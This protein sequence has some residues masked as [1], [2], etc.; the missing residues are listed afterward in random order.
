MKKTI[1]LLLLLLG[2][3]GCDV[4]RGRFSVTSNSFSAF[5][6]NIGGI[7][8]VNGFGAK[9]FNTT[10]TDEQNLLY[11][12]IVGP[13]VQTHGSSSASGFEKYVT[14]LDYSWNAEKSAFAVSIHWNR[15]TDI[16]VIG[17]QEFDRE[18]GNVFVVR[19]D[20]NSE[21]TS[22]QLTNLGSHD[23]FSEA[24]KHIQQQLPNDQL[25]NSLKLYGK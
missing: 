11:I 10:D 3:V 16:V 15:K 12:L 22:Q 17:K 21:M 18:K 9:P 4:Q 1:P 6:S 24:L 23:S 5:S 14:T 2:I 20:A 25:I 13:S 8:I 19:L 7:D